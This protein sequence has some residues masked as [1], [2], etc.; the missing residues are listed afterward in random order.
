MRSNTPK[1]QASFKKRKSK[2]KKKAHTYFSPSG[3]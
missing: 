3:A 2:K 1:A